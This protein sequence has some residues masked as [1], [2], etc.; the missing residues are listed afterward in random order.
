MRKNMKKVLCGALVCTIAASTVFTTNP[1]AMASTVEY[2]SEAVQ[3]NA[4]AVLKIHAKSDKALSMHYWCTDK[5]GTTWPGEA[6]SEDS[7]M[8]SGW[9]YFETDKQVE[10]LIITCNG[11]QKFSGDGD[12]TDKT[13]GEWWFADGKWSQT[14]PSGG[15]TS[16]ATAT[17]KPTET[18]STTAT[19][20]P[21]PSASTKEE[22]KINSVTPEDKSVLTAGKETT[23]K[24]DAKSEIN[25]GLVY[26][27]FEV[28]CDGEFVGD[29]HYVVG[30]NSFKFT[31]KAGKK[32]S[33]T[34]YAQA[35]DEDNTTVKETLSYTVDGTEATNEPIEA[36]KAPATNMPTATATPAPTQ[37]VDQGGTSSS[38]VVSDI[39]VELNSS[40]SKITYGSKITLTS[41][42]LGG[43]EPFSYRFRAVKGGKETVISDYSTNA[44]VQWKP[45]AVGTYVVYV[46][47]VDKGSTVPVSAMKKITVTSPLKISKVAAKK[48]GKKVVVSAT[49]AKS[50]GNVKYK[51]VVKYNNKSIKKTGYVSSKKLTL[52]N[53][54][55]GSYSVIVYAK[56]KWNVIVTKKVTFKVTAKK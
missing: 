11:G 22:I 30:E 47:V 16:S 42:V 14:N 23:I 53:L 39:A 27:K 32:Y 29:H 6:M 51:Y 46:D 5:S 33:V 34:V 35:H 43:T 50:T 56:D 55:K 31:P 28:K 10:G 44:S 24:V 20:T 13:S 40:K 17:P 54:K 19:A 48:S 38:G 15:S 1:K 37:N 7:A 18:S 52:K 4:E 49:V 45:T 9:Y 2:V 26:Y 3:N 41:E 36:T 8:G 12:I 25:D 21:K